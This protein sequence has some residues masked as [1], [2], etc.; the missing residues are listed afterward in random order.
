M[1]RTQDR[2]SRR[3]EREFKQLDNEGARE[4]KRNQGQEQERDRG[5][6]R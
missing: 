5:R 6:D 1:Q 2:E 3:Q 4:Q